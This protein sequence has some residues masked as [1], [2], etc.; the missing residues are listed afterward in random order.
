MTE[1]QIKAA[2]EKFEALIREQDARCEA[3]K[4]QGDFVDFTKLE[5]DL[6]KI[7]KFIFEPSSVSIGT[8]ELTQPSDICKA[9]ASISCINP[10]APLCEVALILKQR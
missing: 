4:T 7:Q 10:L 3:I 2:L 9:V 8:D 5:R 6:A 1:V